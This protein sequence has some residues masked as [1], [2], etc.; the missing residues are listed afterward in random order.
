MKRKILFVISA[1][2]FIFSVNVFAGIF[3]ISLN[4]ES[5]LG[6]ASAPVHSDGKT[7]FCQGFSS[8]VTCTCLQQKDPK[9]IC[10]NVRLV[11]SDMRAR[12]RHFGSNWLAIACQD[13]DS[14]VS[15]QECE[16]QWNCFEYGTQGSESNEKPSD[17]ECFGGTDETHC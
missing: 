17:G 5:F 16:D 10:E 11:Y 4:S 15:T 7:K 2:I 14:D 1:A 8:V 3:P 9:A 13:N 12:Y 6:C